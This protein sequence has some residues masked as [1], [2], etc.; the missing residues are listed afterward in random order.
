MSSL[1]RSC[2]LIDSCRP[3]NEI[4][5]DILDPES[6]KRSADVASTQKQIG[7]GRLHLRCIF[8]I[9][10]CDY[11]SFRNSFLAEFC[12]SKFPSLLLVDKKLCA[13]KLKKTAMNY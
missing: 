2:Q 10:D 6:N 1:L 8:T 12:K 9:L 4:C 5:A 7:S 13:I 11:F 3:S